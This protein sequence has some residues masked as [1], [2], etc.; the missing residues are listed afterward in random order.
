MID[1]DQLYFERQDLVI[2]VAQRRESIKKCIGSFQ[3]QFFLTLYLQ[4][5]NKNIYLDQ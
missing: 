2:V 5:G 3:I 1:Q 4:V